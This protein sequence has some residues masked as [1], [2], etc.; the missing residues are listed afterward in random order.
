MAI[1]IE[2]FGFIDPREFRITWL[3]NLLTLASPMIA[4]PETCSVYLIRYL[5]FY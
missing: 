5:R 1:V 3:F 4:I 2:S